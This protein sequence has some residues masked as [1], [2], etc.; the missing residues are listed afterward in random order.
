MTDQV[1]IG[2][3]RDVSETYVKL[4]RSI[5]SST[6]WSEDDQT[7]LTWISMLAMADQNGYVGASIPGIAAQARVPLEAAEKAIEKFLAPD[8]YSRSQEFE[9]RRIEVADRG[10]TILNYDRFRDMR[11]EEA[12]KTYERERKRAQRKK[13]SEQVTVQTVPKKSR[14]V[15]KSP[16]MSA[17][18]EEQ[19]D[20]QE[21]KKLLPAGR[22]WSAEACDDWIDVTHGVA[23]GGQIGKHLKPVVDACGWDDVRPAWQR[24]LDE[25][26]VQFL[27]PAR[28]AQTYG[29]WST[30]KPLRLGEDR[31]TTAD[32]ATARTARIEELL[33]EYCPF[34][35]CRHRLDKHANG[36]C[37]VC[38]HNGRECS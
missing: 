16:A 15:P 26:E 7:R 3:V 5:L 28:F 34:E 9:G 8:K 22:S 6:I 23:P 24:Y 30:S 17:Q 36:G 12:R 4:F 1:T 10:W 14:R 20:L 29:R 19:E 31:T 37:S 11:D 13:K 32:E 27:S 21:E 2:K 38:R 18:E 35:S 33:A 25:T